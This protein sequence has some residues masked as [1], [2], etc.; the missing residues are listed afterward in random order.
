MVWESQECLGEYA[1][2]RWK[3][4]FFLGYMSVPIEVRCWPLEKKKENSSFINGSR[5]SQRE[6]ATPGE[7]AGCA[8]ED[9][10]RMF[11]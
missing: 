6:L 3:G 11:D 7:S 5:T 8:Q 10:N 9:S 4:V 2:F 1:Y